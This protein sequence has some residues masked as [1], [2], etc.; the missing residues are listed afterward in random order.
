MHGSGIVAQKKVTLRKQG[1]E[2]GN[3][4]FSCEIDRLAMHVRNDGVGDGGF[5][6][7]AEE[8]Y[9]GVALRLETVGPFSEALGRPA[10]SRTV[11]GACADGDATGMRSRAGFQEGFGG[12]L[13]RGIGN[14]ERDVVHLGEDCRAS[15]RDG[16]I[17]GNKTFRELEFRRIWERGWP[18]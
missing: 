10:F 4:C 6:G 14:L 2:I 11:R 13:S 7:G 8:N 15:L 16:A 5:G 18:L 3:G 1:G 9:V 17:R 12:M